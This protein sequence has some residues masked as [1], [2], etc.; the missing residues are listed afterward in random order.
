MK[1][2]ISL[3]AFIILGVFSCFAQ[4]PSKGNFPKGSISGLIL[5]K[6]SKSIVEYATVSVFSLRD[7][8]LKSGGITNAKGIFVIKDLK[9]G[10]YYV[11]LSFIGYSKKRISNISVSKLNKNPNIGKVY[12]EMSSKSIGEVLVS[13]D[14]LPVQYQ[15][16]KKVI[17]VGR[18]YTASTGTAVDVLENVPSVSVDLEGNVSLRGSSG[19]TVLVDGKPSVLDA[20]DVLTQIPASVIES[21]EIITNPSAKYDPDGTAGI[22]NI[23]TKKGK[24]KGTSGVVN[25]SAGSYDNYGG[26]ILINIKKEKFN[27]YIGADYNKRNFLGD[28][29]SYNATTSKGLTTIIQSVGESEFSRK[30]YGFRTGIDFYANEKNLFSL[31]VRLGKHEMHRGSNLSYLKNILNDANSLEEYRSIDDFDREQKFVSLEMSH[32][33]DFEKK[34]HQLVTQATF[35]LRD[36]DESS[37]NKLRTLAG[38]ISEGKRTFE[39]GPNNKI[40][41][42]TDYTLPLGEKEKLEAGYQF[43]MYTNESQSKS[44]DWDNNVYIDKPEL[45]ND[46]NYTREIHSIYSIYAGA[47]KKMHYQL[48]LRAEY[49]NRKIESIIDNSD[50]SLNRID[51]FPSLHTQYD[52]GD[53]YQLMASYTRRI[54]RARSWHLEPFITWTD[55]YNVR[56]GNPDLKPQYIDSYELGVNKRLGKHNLSFETY[57]RITNNKVERVKSLYEPNVDIQAVGVTLSTV[58]NVGTDYSL[59]AEVM[60]NLSL[61][62]WWTSDLIGNLFHYKVEGELLGKDYSNESITY[63]FRNNNTF[64]LNTTTRVQLS[65]NYNGP[66]ESAQGERK[67][68]FMT[69]LAFRK[70]FMNRKISATFNVRDVFN[71]GKHESITSTDNY[72]NHNVFDF[73]GPI[74]SLK[75]SYKINNYKA[76]RRKSNGGDDMGE[77]FEM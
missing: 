58:E 62:K 49:T 39:N 65:L 22:L 38:D 26:D 48:G 27:F 63:T 77:G 67:S 43:D 25:L 40:R 45:A 21:I 69:N 28:R 7:S 8:T 57:Y 23:I 70:D 56:K 73:K 60:L 4:R 19:F 61:A 10:K 24:L 5:D 76:K 37:D 32:T 55:A 14:R 13:T 68:F 6:N 33:L 15:I 42:K 35:S 36:A 29:E 3:F 47:L 31:G 50:F 34:G 1:K 71:T 53:D 54:H 66:R 51:L 59:G 30:S 41:I 20:S 17:P 75:L 74:F 72:Y 2:T 44:Q 12:L 9:P 52:L 46:V 11:D 18:H 16:D 64:K